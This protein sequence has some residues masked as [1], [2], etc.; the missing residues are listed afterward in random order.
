MTLAGRLDL[1][2]LRIYGHE[3]ISGKV[4]QSIW[5]KDKRSELHIGLRD[6]FAAYAR[7]PL[8]L[9]FSVSFSRLYFVRRQ[10]MPSLRISPHFP[11]AIRARWKL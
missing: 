10:C 7:V 8:C 6:G 9:F 2:T 1:V 4:R 3:K 5:G 11:R